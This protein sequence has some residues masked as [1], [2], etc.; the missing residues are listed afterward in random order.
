MAKTFLETGED[1]SLVAGLNKDHPA[2]RQTGLRERGREQVLPRDAPQDAP[3]H[4]G[5]DAGGP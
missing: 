2:G 4:P 5:D 1:R 3:P